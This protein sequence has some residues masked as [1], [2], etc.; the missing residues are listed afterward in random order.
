MTPRPAGVGVAP[1]EKIGHVPTSDLL[2]ALQAAGV[3]DA[4]DSALTRSLY[5]SDAGLYRIPPRVGRP[6]GPP[7][8]PH[9]SH[10]PLRVEAARS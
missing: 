9:P 1:G 4:D 8:A 7:A 2:L 3:G 6:T 5:A 10:D